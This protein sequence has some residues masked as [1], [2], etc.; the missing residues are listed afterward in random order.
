[1]HYGR[2]FGDLLS[3]E[4][5]TMTMNGPIRELSTVSSLFLE[6]QLRVTIRVLLHKLSS[7]YIDIVAAA[8]IAVA[9][10]DCRL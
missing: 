2:G 7:P 3:V 6:H 8:C 4:Y 9:K 10:V 5:G 1:M